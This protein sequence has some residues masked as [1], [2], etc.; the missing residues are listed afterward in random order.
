MK[1]VTKKSL[2]KQIEEEIIKAK[3]LGK[4]VEYVE[5]TMKEYEELK[6]EFQFPNRSNGEIKI[7][8]YPVK[9]DLE[10]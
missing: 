5:I 9:I 3:E 4:E 1:V 10:K 8:G 2:L 7:S 6:R